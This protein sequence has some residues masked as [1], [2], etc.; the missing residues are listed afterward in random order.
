M[1]TPTSCM[2]RTVKVQ[3]MSSSFIFG[4]RP[5]T[6]LSSTWLTC[7]SK[8]RLSQSFATR[9]MISAHTISLIIGLSRSGIEMACSV[10][11]LETKKISLS[12]VLSHRLACG[13]YKPRKNYPTARLQWRHPPSRTSKPFLTCFRRLAR[14]SSMKITM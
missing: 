4:M 7:L 10:S 3:P 5:V 11:F 13:R 9:L 2:S 12:I 14:L 6:A 1:I 8:E